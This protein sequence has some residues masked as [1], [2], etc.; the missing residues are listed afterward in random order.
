MHGCSQNS[1]SE[2]RFALNG[3]M[4]YFSCVFASSDS[5]GHL[6]VVHTGISNVVTVCS[7]T[8]LPSW[9]SNTLGNCCQTLNL[10][11]LGRRFCDCSKN[12]S[13]RTVF[14]RGEL[15]WNYEVCMYIYIY[16]FIQTSGPDLEKNTYSIIIMQG[17][18]NT[19]IACCHVKVNPLWSNKFNK[20]LHHR[21]ACFV[22]WQ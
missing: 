8:T 5:L 13:A 11:E 10:G 18:P 6:W 4:C 14:Q 19:S 1:S 17:L 22:S 3:D 20:H 16:K 21:A 9:M 2:I 7:Q 15:Q 12:S